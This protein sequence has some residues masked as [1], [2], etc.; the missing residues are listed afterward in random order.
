VITALV[1]VVAL[2]ASAPLIPVGERK[3]LPAVAVPDLNGRSTRV[4]AGDVV[5]VAFWASWCRPCLSELPKLQAVVA[6]HAGVRGVAVSVDA[7]SAIGALRATEK[8]LK[9]QPAWRV[10]H[11][12]DGSALLGRVMPGSAVPVVVVLDRQ[13]RVAFR[14]EGYT[15]GNEAVVD[16]VVAALL[17]EA[18]TA[19]SVAH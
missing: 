17:A 19:T 12:K 4:A 6:A 13:G 9:L 8:R 18:G 10:L 2:A 16:A 14:H 1:A 3:P 5:V 11:D 7:G 15:P